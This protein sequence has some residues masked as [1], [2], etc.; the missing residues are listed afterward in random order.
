MGSSITV[1]SGTVAIF[2][3]LGLYGEIYFGVNVALITFATRVLKN[4]T[5]SYI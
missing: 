2:P 4:N 3:G 1:M 5:L